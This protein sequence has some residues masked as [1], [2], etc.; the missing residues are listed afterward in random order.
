ME[1]FCIPRTD[2]SPEI[3][4]DYGRSVLTLRGESY[5]EN[6]AAFY[7]P[8]FALLE[9]FFNQNSPK[10]IT[11]NIELFY[12]NSS[13]AKALMNLFLLLERATENGNSV[14]IN[15]HVVED[16]DTIREFGE[17]FAE[18]IEGIPFHIVTLPAPTY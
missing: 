11:V 1:N 16:D 8:L 15:W 14:V 7:G 6:V 17:E 10:F 12:F 3:Q 18:D 4:F 5:P 9:N 13:S 2:R